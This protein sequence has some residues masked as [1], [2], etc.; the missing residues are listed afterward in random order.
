MTS[1]GG[2]GADYELTVVGALGPVLRAMVEPAVTTSC[3]LL[4]IVRVR[5]H[6]GQDLVDVL[7]VLGSRGLEALDIR[8]I[9]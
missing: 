1:D 3:G 4:T 9:R 6:D 5:G 8:T 7:D 2:P